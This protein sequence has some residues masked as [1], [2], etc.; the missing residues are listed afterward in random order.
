MKK[1]F[2]DKFYNTITLSGAAIASFSFGLILFLSILDLLA[3]EHNPY[4]GIITF[5]L[6]P[7]VLILGL[8]LIA[9]G[10]YREDKRLK[11]G[12]EAG[13]H[14]PQIDLNDPKQRRAVT[15]FVTGTLVLIVFTAFGSFKAYEYTES[16]RFCG[17]TCHKVMEPEYTAYQASPHSKV[18]CVNCHIGPGTGWF[19][20]SKLSGSYQVYSVLFNKYPRPIPT[21]IENLRPARETCEQCHWTKHLYFEKLRKIDYYS[22]DEANS[23]WS[24]KIAMNIG[25]GNAETGFVSGIHW[26]VNSNNEITYITTDSKRMVI[27]WVKIKKANGEETIYKSSNTSLKEIEEKKTETR[28]MDCIDCHNR[29]AHIYYPSMISVNNYLSLGWIDKSIPFIKSVST[30]ALDKD[31]TTKEIALD[32]IKQFVENFYQYSYPEFYNKNTKL[33]YNAIEQLQKI[34]ARN[35]FPGMRASWK[36][37]PMQIGHMYAPGCFRCHDGKHVSDKG[38]V[39]SKDCNLCHTIISEQYENEEPQYSVKGLAYTHPVEIGKALY[40]M[41][42]SDCHTKNMEVK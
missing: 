39:I 19:V 22:N 3:K 31:Y 8:L 36:N 9:Y 20:R 10:I 34:Y 6:L 15:L 23:K 24:L 35:Y 32:S 27:P 16:D 30:Q 40:D 38:K 5:I 11:R 4:Y 26:H 13:P 12:G 41:N 7:S 25:E 21:P 33:I 18:G 29:P 28:I 42:C 1:K 2:P 17:E 37:Y 14:L